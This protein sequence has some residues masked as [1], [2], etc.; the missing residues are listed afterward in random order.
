MQWNIGDLYDIAAEEIP[1]DRVAIIESFTGR[2]R[3]WGDLISR[4]NNLAKGLLK[5]GAQQGDKVAIYM[6]NCAEYIEAVIACEKARLVPVNINFRYLEDELRYVLDN[7]DATVIVYEPAFAENLRPLQNALPNVRLYLETGTDTPALPDAQRLEQHAETGDGSALNIERSPDDLFFVY[8]GGTTGLPKAVMWPHDTLF[9]MIGVNAFSPAQ[10]FPANLDEYRQEL[11]GFNGARTIIPIPL[12]HG[13]GVHIAQTTLLYGG[14]VV[15]NSN[16]GFN[17]IQL[18]D[19]IEQSQAQNMVIVGDAFGKP[20]LD[21]LNESPNRWDLGNLRSILS[22]AMTF[23]VVT[24]KGLLKHMPHLV[25]VDTLGASETPSIALTVSTKDSC[26]DQEMQM[27]TNA[28]TKVFKENL[29]TEAPEE[30]VPGSDQVGMLARAGNIPIGYYKDA[31]KSAATFP[32]I[33]GVR[34]AIPGDYAK[35]LSDGSIK[36]LG[37]GNVSINSG[38]EKI[39]PDE[40][41][42]AIKRHPQVADAALVGIPDER[43]G[44]AATALVQ[45]H[46]DEALDSESIRDMVRSQLAAYK[47]PK[48]VLAVENINRG[49]NGKLDYQTLA[50]LA[51]QEASKQK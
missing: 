7:S 3:S 13:A 9:R 36:L 14:C 51:L 4:T 16:T 39:Y 19:A 23:S 1:S 28:D 27:A 24:K 32:T 49:A 42:C 10:K 22:S 2:E 35:V 44:Q 21:A 48:N 46:K 12:M 25:I 6:R 34:Y 33:D 40:V 43:W 26:Q 5:S 18:L 30:V 11:T 8:T 41:E 37:R 15:L 29:F 45:L 17:P 20:L 50:K 47:I 31:E 38:G